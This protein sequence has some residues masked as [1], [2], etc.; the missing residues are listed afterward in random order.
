VDDLI[1]DM[2]MTYEP[3]QIPVVVC[4]SPVCQPVNLGEHLTAAGF[5]FDEKEYWLGLDLQVENPLPKT[6]DGVDVRL[7]ETDAD[8]LTFAEIFLAGFEM[9]LDIAPMVADMMKPVVS[10][11]GV[12]YYIASVNGEDVGTNSLYIEGDYGV[13]ASS[14]ILPTKRGGGA[15]LQLFLEAIKEGQHQGKDLL[16]TQTVKPR[17]RRMLSRFGFFDIFVREIYQLPLD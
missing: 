3:H 9:P 11:D 7:I 4:L 12:Y 6:Y 17:V 14:T 13:I 10:M 1:E 15:I 16:M 8:V 2:R 5:V